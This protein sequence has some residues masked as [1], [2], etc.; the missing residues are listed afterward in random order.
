MSR[1]PYLGKTW[2]SISDY[3]L[4]LDKEMVKGWIN[5][6]SWAMS[7]GLPRSSGKG[8]GKPGTRTTTGLRKEGKHMHF[9]GS[10]TKA[11]ACESKDLWKSASPE[12][13]WVSKIVKVNFSKTL[14]I[15]K[16]FPTT[17]G[18]EPNLGKN[19]QD[20]I[21]LTCSLLIPSPLQLHSSLE[22]HSSTIQGKTSSH[23][24]RQT[25]EDLPQ[26][27]LQRTVTIWRLLQLPGHC[28]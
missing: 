8:W 24:G 10:R 13:Q 22:N 7:N 27:P 11:I 25:G 14:E 18:K 20:C 3:L 19:R 28:H 15:N 1:N 6:D 26:S 17:Q 16:M 5:L 12:K 9:S 23:W 4:C 21:I 2:S